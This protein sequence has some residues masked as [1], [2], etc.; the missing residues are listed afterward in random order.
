MD[1]WQMDKTIRPHTNYTY[2]SSS[3]IETH[4]LK[5]PTHSFCTDVNVR[6]VWTSAVI[7]SAAHWGFFMHYV[8]QHSGILFCNF[9]SSAIFVA[10][11]L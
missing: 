5:L 9:M 10:E 11:L 6:G 7:E 1:I 2:R 4:A 3:A 8:F